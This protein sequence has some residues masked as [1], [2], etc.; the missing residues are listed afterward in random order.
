MSLPHYASQPIEYPSSDGKPMADNTKQ[1]RWIITLYNNLG[2]YYQGQEVFVAANLLW[3]P[4]EGMP[5]VRQTPDV[6][7]AF[8]R[9]D[10]DRSS[11]QQWKEAG[12]V[13]QVVFEIL[14]PG[15]S[16]MEMVRKLTFYRQYGV[17]E[18]I[19][20]DPGIKDGDAESFVPYLRDVD[21]MATSQFETVDWVSPRLGIRFRQEEAEVKV[22]YPD[23]TP[24]QSFEAMK[25]Q[26]EAERARAEEEQKRAE[27]ER[28]RAEVEK[29]RADAAEAELARL[30]KLLEERGGA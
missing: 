6:L 22:Y 3:Y 17:E 24:F 4:V 18:V 7:L 16:T 23:G 28:Q 26:W 8:G 10:G 15:N 20:I 12:V 2:S 9:P 11:Y 14:S 19:V 30:R 29:Q 21:R 1:T 25:A 13:P 5:T 27:V